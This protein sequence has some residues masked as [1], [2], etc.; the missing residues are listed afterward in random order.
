MKWFKLLYVQVLIA[1]VLGVVAGYYF[2]GFLL[3]EIVNTTQKQVLL[4]IKGSFSVTLHHGNR[5]ADNRLV[6]TDKKGG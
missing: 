6:A 5:K 3:L 4:G 2:P 1:I